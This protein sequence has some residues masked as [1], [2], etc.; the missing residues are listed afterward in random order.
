MNI[1]EAGDA[2]EVLVED[3]PL[4][5]V[6]ARPV[7]PREGHPILGVDAGGTT[8]WSAIVAVFPNGRIE[9]VAAFAGLD[10][11]GSPL[12]V[13]DI[14]KRDGQPDGTYQSLVDAGVLWCCAGKHEVDLVWFFERAIDRLGGWPH[15]AVGDRFRRGAVRDGLR[16]LCGLVDRSTKYEHATEDVEATRRFI[17]DGPATVEPGT[18]GLLALAI[19]ES[20]I[21][22]DDA[23]NLRVREAAAPAKS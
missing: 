23:G 9:G 19:A 11:E 13:R 12:S 6:Y 10:A 15:V 3:G 5:R 4:E 17:L 16:G 18:R 21:V 8:A 7:A 2:R 20:M 14:E 22:R 1:R